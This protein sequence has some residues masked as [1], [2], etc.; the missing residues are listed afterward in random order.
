MALPWSVNQVLKN[1]PSNVTS[2]S[3][4]QYNPFSHCTIFEKWRWLI[5][6]IITAAV[7]YI[8]NEKWNTNNKRSLKPYKTQTGK[9][10]AF[11]RHAH[12]FVTQEATLSNI[13][14]MDYSNYQSRNEACLHWCFKLDWCGLNLDQPCP[15]LIHIARKCIVSRLKLDWAN[16]CTVGGLI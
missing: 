1:I 14:T 2:H 15:H 8:E 4:W 3:W 10:L 7:F 6:Y 9:S 16:P 11:N 5:Q 12:E 13:M